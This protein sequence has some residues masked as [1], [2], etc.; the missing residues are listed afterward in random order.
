MTIQKLV[1]GVRFFRASGFTGSIVC[2]IDVGV[3]GNWLCLYHHLRQFGWQT[4]EHDYC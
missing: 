3:S 4:I 1:I 2:D